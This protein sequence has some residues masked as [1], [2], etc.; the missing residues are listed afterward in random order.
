MAGRKGAGKNGTGPPSKSKKNRSTPKTGLRPS[1]PAKAGKTAGA[2]HKIALLSPNEELETADGSL[3]AELEAMTCIYELGQFSLQDSEEAILQK[4]LDAAITFTKADMGNI[5]LFDP[6]SGK[7][8]IQ[9]HRGFQKD[10]LDFWGI[11]DESRGS[12]GAALKRGEQIVVEDVTKSPIFSGSP[13]LEVQLK[14]GVRA[15]QSTPLRTRRGNVLGMISTH[16]KKPH[17]PGPH[18]LRFLDL[19]AFQTAGILELRRAEQ[20][21]K[22]LADN[23]PELFSYIGRDFRYRYTNHAHEDFWQRPITEIVGKSLAEVIGPRRFEVE[24][25]HFEAVLRGEEAVYEEEYVRGDGLHWMQVHLVPQFPQQGEVPGFYRLATDITAQKRNERALKESENRMRA[26]LNTASYAIFTIDRRGMIIDANAA[27]SQMFG[28]KLC[29]LVGQDLKILMSAYYRDEYDT[30]RKRHH[31]ETREAGPMRIESE[32]EGLRKD[33]STFPIDLSVNEVEDQGI[34]ISIIRDIS[35][36]KKA[37]QLVDQYRNDLRALSSEL[38]I[39]EE[40]ER[41]RLAESLH[42]GLGHAIYHAR[43]RLDQS[44]GISGDDARAIGAILEQ[45]GKT[46]TTLTFE[47]SPP[48]LKQ[49]GFLP[50][51]KWLARNVK[52]Q[53]GLSVQIDNDG[54]RIP[55]EDSIAMILFRSVRELLTNVAKHAQT[56]SARISITKSGQNLQVTIEDRG[57]GFDPRQQSLLVQKGH[58]GLFSIRERLEYLNGSLQVQSAPGAGVTATLTVPLASEGAKTGTG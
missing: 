55:L 24:R 1:E 54:Q 40:R 42:D 50:A 6:V 35:V 23:V 25:P 18:L 31:R 2:A 12:S 21:F 44:T 29:E 47:L 57:K 14:A 58:F 9:A 13:G 41:R 19:L 49:L 52:Q 8:S 10:W 43:M 45:M 48:V 53:Y 7:L 27:A 38:I 3:A 56:D 39:T 11:V 34:F 33:G 46:V 16:F 4:V 32:A 51:I 15:I 37:E 22:V 5:Q 28:Y 36:R 30:R 17:R 26:I 20:E